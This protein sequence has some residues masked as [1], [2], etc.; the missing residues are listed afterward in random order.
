VPCDAPV[1]CSL[2]IVLVASGTLALKPRD[3]A[4][5]VV[6]MT[7]SRADVVHALPAA[8]LFNLQVAAILCSLARFRG[9]AWCLL[10]CHKSPSLH[11]LRPPLLY[12][13]TVVELHNASVAGEGCLNCLRGEVGRS[14]FLAGRSKR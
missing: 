7:A 4:E 5:L 12:G 3:G 6:R 13:M 2:E 10:D 9:W 1:P 11:F 8:R 14:S